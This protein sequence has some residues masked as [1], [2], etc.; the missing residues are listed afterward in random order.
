M[1]NEEA[2][3]LIELII[4]TLENQVGECV[5]CEYESKYKFEQ[6]CIICKRSKNDYWT[7]AEK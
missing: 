2:I 5:G 3:K 6:P 7:G 1:T 4:K